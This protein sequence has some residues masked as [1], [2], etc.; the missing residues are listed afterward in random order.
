MIWVASVVALM[1]SPLVTPGDFN[2]NY[3]SITTSIYNFNS[4]Y[5]D[6]VENT[7]FSRPLDSGLTEDV[8]FVYAAIAMEHEDE[9]V[10]ASPKTYSVAANIGNVT[11]GTLLEDDDEDF[12]FIKDIDEI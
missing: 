6:K 4:T 11:V 10:I 2:Q 5:N 3:S 9:P 8:D 1:G 7:M 12:S